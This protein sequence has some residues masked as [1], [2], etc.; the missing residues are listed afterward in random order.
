MDQKL[1][2]NLGIGAFQILINMNVIDISNNSIIHAN[3][4]IQ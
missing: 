1:S 3:R 2:M 4:I